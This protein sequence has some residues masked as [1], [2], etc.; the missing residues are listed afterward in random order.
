MEAL[1]DASGRG[2]QKLYPRSTLLKIFKDVPSPEALH[3]LVQ[4]PSTPPPVLQATLRLNCFTLGDTPDNIF[5][6]EIAS[7]R[8]VDALKEV[9]KNKKQYL[10]PAD[11]LVLHRTSNE[12]A[13]LDD[14]DALMEALADASRR[15]HYKLGFRRTLL[16]IFKDVP[17]HNALHILVQLPLGY[18]PPVAVPDLIVTCLVRGDKTSQAFL[19]EISGTKI[20][21]YLKEAIRNKMRVFDDISA[22]HLVL[23]NVSFPLDETLGEKLEGLDLH[24]AKQLSDPF[25]TLSNIDF[26]P[27]RLHI[28]VEAPLSSL[29]HCLSR[30]LV[31]SL[32]MPS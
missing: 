23:Y 11:K 18:N 12:V 25:Q 26:P 16:E 14:D 30:L 19:V 13:T 9:I 28:V 7:T 24:H 3:I 32:T 21:A 5:P 6:V 29:F 17:P 10:F 22:S 4:L 1:A 15:G 8:T 20:V 27:K 2:H 31:I